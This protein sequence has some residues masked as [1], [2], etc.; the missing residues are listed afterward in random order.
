MRGSGQWR[1]HIKEVNHHSHFID[2][3]IYA[4]IL[5]SGG[6]STYLILLVPHERS[7]LYQGVQA[8]MDELKQVTVVTHTCSVIVQQ[9]GVWSQPSSDVLPSLHCYRPL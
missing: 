1:N 2:L 4:I 8:V 7:K 5:R 3:C 6:V 9:T